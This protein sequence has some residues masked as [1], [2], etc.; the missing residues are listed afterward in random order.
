ML[1]AV[2]NREPLGATPG[3]FRCAEGR[4]TPFRSAHSNRTGTRPWIREAAGAQRRGCSLLLADRE[5]PR[6]RDA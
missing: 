2:Q 5:Q 4:A 6:R 1:F 3:F